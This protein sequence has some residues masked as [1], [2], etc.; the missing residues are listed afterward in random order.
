MALWAVTFQGS[1]PI[2]GP[3]IGFVAQHSSPRY[4][5][6]LGGVSCLLAAALGAVAVRRTPP[7][8]RTGGAHPALMDWNAYEQAHAA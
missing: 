7:A 2:G 1:T 5:L 4:G 8:Q 3:I 6:A